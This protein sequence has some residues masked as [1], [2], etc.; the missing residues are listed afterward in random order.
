MSHVFQAHLRIGV[1]RQGSG[2]GCQRRPLASA[3]N[4]ALP[5]FHSPLHWVLGGLLRE[6]ECPPP[7]LPPTDSHWDWTG[8][9]PRPAACDSLSLWRPSAPQA[10]NQNDSSQQALGLWCQA[11]PNTACS[12]AEQGGKVSMVPLGIPRAST[13]LN[14]E[15]CFASLLLALRPAVGILLGH[16]F[17]YLQ[18]SKM[19]KGISLGGCGP[20]SASAPARALV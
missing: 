4:L 15:H 17:P 1:R 9:S 13:L 14:G 20:G 12:G 18:L 2:C 10:P 11:E 19:E 16:C 7:C 3:D 6:Q 8:E 5:D